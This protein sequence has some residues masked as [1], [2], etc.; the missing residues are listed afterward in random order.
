[1]CTL[2]STS[3]KAAGNIFNH[4][5]QFDPVFMDTENTEKVN[6]GYLVYRMVI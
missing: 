2:G 1:M 5:I 6:L 3:D 4:K